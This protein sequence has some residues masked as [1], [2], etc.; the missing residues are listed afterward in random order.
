MGPI[1]APVLPGGLLH[2]GCGSG[3]RDCGGARGDMR[4]IGMTPAALS[5][6]VRG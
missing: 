4:P 6:K 1:V 5:G 2:R 3:A